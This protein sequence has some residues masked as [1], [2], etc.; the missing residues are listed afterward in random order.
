MKL[1]STEPPVRN[2]RFS[3]RPT[4]V[5]SPSSAEGLDQDQ[6]PTDL[7]TH[8]KRC[9]R[10]RGRACGDTREH[11]VPLVKFEHVRG[12]FCG[13]DRDS[14]DSLNYINERWRKPDSASSYATSTASS[15]G[16][17]IEG[18][19]FSGL[20]TR[21]EI[22]HIRIRSARKVALSHAGRFV[23][24]PA[25]TASYGRVRATSPS[26]IFGFNG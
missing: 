20:L 4:K 13:F 8:W 12:S 18:S 7:T 14:F 3:N 1:V 25:V 26:G 21:V 23:A 24:K 5:N 10:C 16:S 2:V 9:A 17:T 11:C 15:I 22:G 19:S 6:P